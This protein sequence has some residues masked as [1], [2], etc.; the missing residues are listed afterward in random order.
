[1][2]SRAVNSAQRGMLASCKARSDRG[3]AHLVHGRAIAR[4]DASQSA[5]SQMTRD[6]KE[7]EKARALARLLWCDSQYFN[8]RQ[9]RSERRANPEL[10]EG[11]DFSISLEAQALGG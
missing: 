7:H 6:A 8:V 3:F 10:T 1:M 2:R 11:T 4:E 5:R 9:P